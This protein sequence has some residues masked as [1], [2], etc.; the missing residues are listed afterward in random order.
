[1]RAFLRRLT[2]FD[3]DFDFRRVWRVGTT[4]SVIVFLISGAG[5]LVRDLNL[6]LDFEGGTAWDVPTAD[7]SVEEVRDVLRPEGQ[8]GAKIQVIGRGDNR[9]VRVQSDAEDVET[10]NAVSEALA[11]A[12]GIDVVDISVSTVGPSWG[13]HLTDKAVR[14]LIWFFIAVSLYIAWRL[15]WKMAVG[16]LASVVHDL[17]IC[18]GF[19][20]LFGIEVTP[21]TVIAFLTILG[22][23]LYDTIV[24]FDRM[25]DN[26]ATVG[27]TGKVTYSSI[28]SLSLNQVL[29]RSLNATISSLLPVVAMLVVGS[30]IMGAVALQEFA[31]ALT[32]GIAVGAFSSILI[33]PPV[34][35]WLKEREPRWAQVRARVSARGEVIPAAAT[36]GP[37]P[38]AAAEVDADRPA[39]PKRTVAPGPA[40]SGRPIPP[41]PRKKGKRR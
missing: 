27:A 36:A 17:V 14:A 26:A 29:M 24:V 19:Y 34:T 8:Q 3:D 32:V 9:T 21:A 16:A 25:Q 33:A 7:L 22:Y 13:E 6:G 10:Q 31:L 5:L 40:P 18:V 20:A 15:E 12:A 37:V 2:S 28:A 41:R 39:T 23:S 11:E 1:M 35:V 38:S 30:A 4:I